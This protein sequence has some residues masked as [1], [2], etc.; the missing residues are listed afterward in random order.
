MLG[1]DQAGALTRVESGEVTAS[2][3]IGGAPGPE[4][5]CPNGERRLLLDAQARGPGRGR[6]PPAG[7]PPDPGVDARGRGRVG[8][9]PP[10]HTVWD[11]SAGVG[12]AVDGRAVGWIWSRGSTTRRAAAS[13]RS[14]SRASPRRASPPRC[15]SRAS[16]RSPS[17]DGSRL[18]FTAEAERAK[19]ENLLV[20]RYSYRQPFGTLS[21][22]L[23]GIEL[24]EGIGVM[25]HQDAIW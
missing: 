5:V 25:E 24:A 12:T 6:R 2:L 13:G 8:R 15:A 9:L 17:T 10:R 22:S 21:G 20:V 16:T 3:A 19:D 1:S 11:W 18:G 14:G 7:R 23:D 4:A